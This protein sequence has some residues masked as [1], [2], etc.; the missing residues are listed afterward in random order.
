MSLRH[1][2]LSSSRQNDSRAYTRTVL[3]SFE[4]LKHQRPL[5]NLPKQNH[6]R[7]DTWDCFYSGRASSVLPLALRLL[8]LRLGRRQQTASLPFKMPRLPTP[9]AGTRLFNRPTSP[10]RCPV[11]IYIICIYVY[12]HTYNTY[13]HLHMYVCVYTH[14]CIFTYICIHIYTYICVY[15]YIYISPNLTY[16]PSQYRYI[17]KY[18]RIY[19]Y[20]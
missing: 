3:M 20:T 16:A 5:L 6:H 4:N 12:I 11:Y 1:P 14:I 15:I 10:N 8:P 18:I 19:I 7:A 17:Y 9:H 2:V 13:I